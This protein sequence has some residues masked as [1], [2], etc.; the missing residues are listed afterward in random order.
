[1]PI[2]FLLLILFVVVAMFC[3]CVW[4]FGILQLL[5]EEGANINIPNLFF[6]EHSDMTGNK[7]RKQYPVTPLFIAVQENHVHVV[8]TLLAANI[9][10]S[11]KSINFDKDPQISK[12]IN[13]FQQK[14]TKVKKTSKFPENALGVANK[15]TNFKKKT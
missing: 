1:M 6:C 7:K 12:R 2:I 8:H 13:K 10:Q 4:L 3:I 14:S 11:K 5:M 15:C 9:R